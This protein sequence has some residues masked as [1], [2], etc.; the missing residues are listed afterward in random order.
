[1]STSLIA[2]TIP[3][4]K[5]RL[6]LDHTK[7]VLNLSVYCAKE[8]IK[9]VSKMFQSDKDAFIKCVALS[10]ILHDIG[11]STSELQ[12]F[13]SKKNC[14]LTED[15]SE[16]KGV[17]HNIYSWA[18]SGIIQSLKDNPKYEDIISHS[19]LYHHVISE[20]NANLTNKFCLRNLVEDDNT[21]NKMKE[22]YL[23]MVEYCEKTFDIQFTNSDK[24]FIED[25]E[26]YVREEQIPT[27]YYSTITHFTPKEWEL[28]AMKNLCRACL[29]FADRMISNAN[30]NSEAFY[31]NDIEYFNHLT[32]NIK[33]KSIQLSDID[34]SNVYENLDESRLNEQLKAVESVE[35]HSNV[36][37]FGNAGIGKTLIGLMWFL[38]TNKKTIWITPRNIIANSTYESLK[39]EIEHIG[40]KDVNIA[41]YHGG[42]FKAKNFDS[43]N[44]VADTDI[45]VT[46]IDSILNTHL[47]NNT[48]VYMYDIYN[49][50]IIFDEYHEFVCEQPL[51]HMFIRLLMT[52]IRYT[53][54]KT[55]LMSATPIDLSMFGAKGELYEH[56]CLIHNGDMNVQINMCSEI[57]MNN[58]KDDSFIITHTVAQA[59][60]LYDL[61]PFANKEILHS[62]YT[63]TDRAHHT[64]EVY[65]SHNKY[66]VVEERNTVVGTNIIGT[67]LDI[68]AKNIYDY[69]YSPEATIQRCCGR[70]GRFGEPYYNNQVEYNVVL[71][72]DN[73]SQFFIRNSYDY[74]LTQ[75][76][77]E[78]LVELDNT[79]ITKIELYNIYNQ[80]KLD[81]K[82]LYSDFYKKCFAVSQDHNIKPYKSTKNKKV[83]G[84]KYVSNNKNSIRNNDSKNVF[85]TAQMVDGSWCDAMEIDM[86]TLERKE[87]NDGR[88]INERK[89]FIKHYKDERFEYKPKVRKIFFTLE[90][91]AKL[92]YT[93]TSP[94]PLFNF[95]Y[96]KNKGLYLIEK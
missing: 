10:A 63:D 1:M 39:N 17:Q 72:E 15:G 67:G 64:N 92:A 73:S 31:N 86:I 5:N 79:M 36:K 45:L 18:F 78:R 56:N 59:Q 12:T 90:E 32:N 22:F 75:K 93:S 82:D 89:K 27:T 70:S 26:E 11:K 77:K 83:D 3:N 87:T 34:W 14:K 19:V 23:L 40:L 20:E 88:N 30:L 25:F 46:N 61:I 95:K 76:W 96:C 43:D 53:D 81:N 21:L 51:F 41:L 35:E 69:C 80:F 28:N 29:I 62:N 2:K 71:K 47:K 48:S 66:S 91:V 94:I 68:S 16:V 37:L 24:T 74:E 4:G 9:N 57:D 65:K 52:R 85:V 44:I 58:L 8:L 84:S 60:K 55:L 33:P 38:K 6:L 54:T 13:Y 50:N 42:E 49:T 7:M